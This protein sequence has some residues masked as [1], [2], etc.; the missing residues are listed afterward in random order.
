[1]DTRSKSKAKLIDTELEIDAELED[2]QY[3]THQDDLSGS[4]DTKDDGEL[5]ESATDGGEVKSSVRPRRPHT[6]S[7][8]D[9]P[10]PP[11]LS[12]I[13]DTFPV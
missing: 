8:P 10:P 4:E 5:E 6:D 11:S 2:Q 12:L 1:M 9:L 13:T 3:T 7:P